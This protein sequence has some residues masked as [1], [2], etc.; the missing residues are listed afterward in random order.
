MTRP[1]ALRVKAEA[2]PQAMRDQRRWVLWRYDWSAEDNR[3]IKV[4]YQPWGVRAKSNDSSTWFTFA[5]VM[6]PYR[7]GNWDGV[8]FV[9][10]DGWSA[11]DLDKCRD[12]ETGILLSSTPVLGTEPAG[13]YRELSPSGTGIHLV[14][15]ADQ[16]GFEIRC[17]QRKFV[18]WRGARFLAITGHGEG[19]PTVDLTDLMRRWL[20]APAPV[21]QVAGHVG[22]QDAALTSD[23]DLLLQAVGSANGDRFLAL[24]RG[25][26]S[27]Y[28]SQSEADLA[29]C[30]MLAFWTNYDAERVDRLFRQSGLY[31]AKWNGSYRSATLNKAVS[32]TVREPEIVTEIRKVDL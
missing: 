23:D 27:A 15:R 28:A 25:D 29:L 4:P 26:T 22:Y 9:I 20:P 13:T 2:I 3:W 24:W 8:G 14:G 1:I 17:D 19:D 31:R 12:A 6:A 5:E 32:S 18:P 7:Q 10:G 30:G 21:R 16:H 11:V